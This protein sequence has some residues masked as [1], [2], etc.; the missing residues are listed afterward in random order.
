VRP[1]AILSTIDTD[2]DG[3]ITPAELEASMR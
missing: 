2:G 1:Q 3:R